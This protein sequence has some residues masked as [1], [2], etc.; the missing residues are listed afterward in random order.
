MKLAKFCHRIRPFRSYSCH[1]I[2]IRLS[3]FMVTVTLTKALISHTL[4]MQEN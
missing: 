4:K 1:D 2:D 3:H